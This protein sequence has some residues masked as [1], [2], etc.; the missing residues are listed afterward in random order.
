MVHTSVVELSPPF[1]SHKVVQITFLEDGLAPEGNEMFQLRLI[2][3]TPFNNTGTIFH[4]SV[5][6]IMQ[7]ADGVFLKLVKVAVQ[8]L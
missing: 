5:T 6:L 3:L 8:L 4:D 7:D 1:I 2:F